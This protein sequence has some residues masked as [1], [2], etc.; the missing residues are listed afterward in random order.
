M[1][2]GQIFVREAKFRGQI[3]YSFSNIKFPRGSYQTDIV[4]RPLC[5]IYCS[6]LNFLPHPCSKPTLNHFQLFWIKGVKAK[7][8]KPYLSQQ[9]ASSSFFLNLYKLARLFTEEFSR[10]NTKNHYPTLVYTT[11]VNGTFRARWLASSEVIS[12][13]LFTSEQPKKNKMAFVGILSQIK[14]LF[15][16]LIIQPVWYK[17]KQSFT[18]V[19]VKVVNVY[20]TPSRLSKYPPLFTF[21]SVNNCYLSSHV[22]N[23]NPRRIGEN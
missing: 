7:Y 8:K 14:L 9:I 18:S 2:F 13:V 19:S 23:L 11:Q 15:A 22:I 4:L 20:L 16:L 1:F 5:C 6:K 21:T 3:C 17:L 12:Q 10:T